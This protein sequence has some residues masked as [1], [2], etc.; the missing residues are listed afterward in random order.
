MCLGDVGGEEGKGGKE[1]RLLLCWGPPKSPPNED[2][3]T[4][5]GLV[6][7]P[8]VGLE[9]AAGFGLMVRSVDLGCRGIA[10]VCGRAGSAPCMSCC[11]RHQRPAEPYAY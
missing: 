9:L 8:E 11:S 7:R 10:R 5:M 2:R 6:F 4:L 1:V 3:S